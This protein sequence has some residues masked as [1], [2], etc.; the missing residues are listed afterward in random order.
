MNATTTTNDDNFLKYAS[1]AILQ[2][3]ESQ[4]T[5]TADDVLAVARQNNPLLDPVAPQTLSQLLRAA[6]SNGVI[7]S[8]GGIKRSSRTRGPI[9][10]WR[11]KNDNVAKKAEVERHVAAKALPFIMALSPGER[12]LAVAVVTEMLE[13]LA[14]SK[15]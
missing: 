2:L 10:I 12:V 5:F 15:I 13:N 3:A 11:S 8:T 1:N 4:E 9:A 14:K 6:A 7:E